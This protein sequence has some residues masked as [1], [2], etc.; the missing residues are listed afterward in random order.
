M[1]GTEQQER[2]M[3]GYWKQPHQVSHGREVEIKAQEA[4]LEGA[5]ART[6]R[7]P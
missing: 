7:R 4:D 3:D 2:H 1:G 6:N 5:N